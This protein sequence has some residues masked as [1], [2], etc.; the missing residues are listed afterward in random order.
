MSGFYSLKDNRDFR[1]VYKYG[2]S[3]ANSILVI[4]VLKNP[5]EEHDRIGI[6]VSKKVG[7]SVVRH[8]IKRQIRETC[9][10]NFSNT[11]GGHDIVIIVREKCRDKS[12]REITEAV[13]DLYKRTRLI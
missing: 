10:L 4:Y 5:E 6:S 8:R 11:S 3:A 13:Y 2:R 9:R 12:Y 7:N 1:K